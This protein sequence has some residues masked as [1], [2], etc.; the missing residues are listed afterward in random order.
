MLCETSDIS[1][2][3]CLALSRA[4]VFI[5]LRFHMSCFAWLAK[6]FTLM[7]FR[8]LESNAGSQTYW[9]NPLG[10]RHFWI[11]AIT[12]GRS[13]LK[14][15]TTLSFDVYD[16]IQ[17][18]S[19][20]FAECKTT[21][22]TSPHTVLSVLFHHSLALSMRCEPPEWRTRII[23]EAILRGCSSGPSGTKQEP[24]VSHSGFQKC[25]RAPQEWIQE[26]PSLWVYLARRRRMLEDLL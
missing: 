21:F 18:P 23:F 24:K 7:F 22:G 13:N 2:H 5:A 12:R 25:G 17:L 8:W 11:S 16:T 3:L 1:R 14:E 19:K 6:K 4:K 15:P 10:S 9:S 26:D 20:I